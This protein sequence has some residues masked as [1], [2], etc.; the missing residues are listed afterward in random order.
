MRRGQAEPFTFDDAQLEIERTSRC[1]KVVFVLLVE[2]EGEYRPAVPPPVC[3]DHDDPRFSDPG[4]GADFDVW[5]SRVLEVD[6]HTA[7]KPDLDYTQL[8]TAEQ[9]LLSGITHE[10]LMVG[11]WSRLLIHE[12]GL[13]AGRRGLLV[14]WKREGEQTLR[15]LEELFA[16]RFGV[17]PWNQLSLTKEEIS[18]AEDGI[19]GRY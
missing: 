9:A 19:L 14:A 13:D 12:E 17:G 18:Q 3:H 11:Y 5:I 2:L 16:A 8:G 1:G 15:W 6:F 7:G 10:R 4:S